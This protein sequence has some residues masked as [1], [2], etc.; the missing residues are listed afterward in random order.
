[1]TGGGAGGGKIGSKFLAPASLGL[2]EDDDA[3]LSQDQFDIR[4]LRLDTWY[5]QTA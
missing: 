1:V 5:S 3:A 4:R 2:I